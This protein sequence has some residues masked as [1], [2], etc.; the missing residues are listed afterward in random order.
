MREQRKLA[1]RQRK[2]TEKAHRIKED[3]LRDDDN[4]F[5]VAYEQQGEVDATVSATDIKVILLSWLSCCVMWYG[6]AGRREDGAGSRC[7]AD[8]MFVGRRAL[9]CVLC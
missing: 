1:D 4:V 2:L 5:D 6:P 8:V 7:A 9:S 3:M